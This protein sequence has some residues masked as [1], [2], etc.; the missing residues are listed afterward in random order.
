MAEIRPP[1]RI[2]GVSTPEPAS[3]LQQLAGR[4]MPPQT[5][6]A[7]EHFMQGVLSLQQAV[8][9]DPRLTPLIAPALQRLYAGVAS[10]DDSSRPV[11]SGLPLPGG[12]VPVLGP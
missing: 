12:R 8:Q 4:R 2:P 3:P 10:T 11:P 7:Q 1:P 5:Q 9:L 6:L